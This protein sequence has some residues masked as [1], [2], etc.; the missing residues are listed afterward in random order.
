[1]E[2]VVKVM[3]YMQWYVKVDMEQ[4]VKKGRIWSMYMIVIGWICPFTLMV[5]GNDD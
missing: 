3:T 2:V 1:M 4:L 5:L